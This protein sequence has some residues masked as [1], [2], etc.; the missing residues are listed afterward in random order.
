MAGKLK[1]FALLLLSIATL[2]HGSSAQTRYVVGGNTGWTVPPGGASTYSNWASNQKFKQGD[3]LVFSFTTGQHDVAKVTKAAFDSCNTT[4]PISILNNG[5]A[6][7]KLNESGEHYYICTVG[8]HCSLG[9]KLAVNVSKQASSPSASP[10]PQPSA[11]PAKSPAPVKAP[12]PAPA[13]APSPSSGAVTYT[14]GDKTGWT[15]P[16]S[17]AFYKTWTSGKTFKVGD[18]LVFNFQKNAHNVAEVTKANYGSCGTASPLRLYNS[19]PV[20][21]TLNKSGEHYFICAFP[22]HCAGGQK[23]AINVT[24][25]SSPATSPSPSSP[26]S[27]TAPAPGSPASSPSGGATNPS[28]PSPSGSS[29]PSSPNS[30]ATSYRVAGLLA[31]LL[32]MAAALLC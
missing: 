23:L 12:S 15:V 3:T 1:V 2:L 20:R 10:A 19:P 6:S 13:S 26:P 29:S 25:A 7:V 14:V 30:G 17:Q 24:G 11:S 28:S 9:Q 16:S 31:T 4:N 32:W 5:P 27:P 22:G 21:M 18:I 8:P